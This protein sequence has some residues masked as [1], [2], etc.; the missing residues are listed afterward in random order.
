MSLPVQ[1]LL[2]AFV[3]PGMFQQ[4]LKKSI[5]SIIQQFVPHSL[6]CS[7]WSIPDWGK[8]TIARV[9]PQV[10]ALR[11]SVPVDIDAGEQAEK[12]QKIICWKEIGFK[13]RYFCETEKQWGWIL[14]T[15]IQ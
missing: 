7:V 5:W 14:K 8:P 1:N 15:P 12:S 9:A 3:Y 10:A 13:G 6:E 4:I 11:Q 2:I